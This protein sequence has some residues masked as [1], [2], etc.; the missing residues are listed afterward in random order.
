MRLK[1]TCLLL[2]AVLLLQACYY[3]NEEE[4]YPNSFCDT[5][6]V[7]WS[8]TINP[9]IQSKCAIPGCHV[10]GGFGPGDFTQYNNVKAAVD[11]GRFEAEV[12][13]A[14]SMPP[15]GR[16]PACQITQ[17]NDWIAQGAPNN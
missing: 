15:S 14:G 8:G 17:I 10:S 2:A 3:D 13:T 4:L 12:I 5:A 1:L 6:N 11:N 9:I 7:T 16:L